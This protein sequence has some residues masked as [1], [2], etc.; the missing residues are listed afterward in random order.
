[1]GGKEGKMVQFKRVLPKGWPSR[2]TLGKMLLEKLAS[3][4][5]RCPGEPGRHWWKVVAAN[6]RWA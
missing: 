2:G 6:S 1:M 5:G 3:R 4:H